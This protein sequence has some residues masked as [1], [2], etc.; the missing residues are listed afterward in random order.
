MSTHRKLYLVRSEIFPI[1]NHS[2]DGRRAQYF[3]VHQRL[4]FGNQY[5]MD[6][7]LAIG[8]SEEAYV[9][10]SGLVIRWSE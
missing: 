3:W 8:V 9:V 1:R 2:S 6:A 4:S 5:Q 7:F 10:V